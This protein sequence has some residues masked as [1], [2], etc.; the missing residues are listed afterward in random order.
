MTH[1]C[2]LQD[3]NELNFLDRNSHIRKTIQ[4]SETIKYLGSTSPDLRHRGYESAT[5]SE[6]SLVSTNPFEDDL[7]IHSTKKANTDKIP[8]KKR[9][10]PQP[11][12]STLKKN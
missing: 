7:E 6:L 5:N 12:V 1:S 9:R 4:Y 11:P 3:M 8:R 2:S 10:A